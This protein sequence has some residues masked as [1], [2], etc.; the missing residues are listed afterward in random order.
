VQV[1]VLAE[2]GAWVYQESEFDRWD[3][4]LDKQD[5]MQVD[6]VDEPIA[7]EPY[8]KSA[9]QWGTGQQGK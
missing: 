7:P 5:K 6:E 1:A 9:G 8:D 4:R 2:W 3:S